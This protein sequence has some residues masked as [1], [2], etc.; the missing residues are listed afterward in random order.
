MQGRVLF[1]T[2]RVPYPLNDGGNLAMKAMIDGYHNAGW[3]VY[4]LSMN[5]SRHY[6]NEEE[7]SDLYNYLYAFET[8]NVDNKVTVQNVTSN[9]LFS[10][11]PSHAVRFRSQ[12]YAV[13]L[14]AV[15]KEFE[16]EVIQ[17]E[18][19][20]LSIYTSILKKSDAR[21]ILRL[22]NIESQIWYRLADE[23][24]NFVKKS[25]LRNLA[26]RI[27]TFEKK[28]FVNYDLLLPIT[29]VDAAVVNRINPS[30][31]TI[32]IPFGI[33]TKKIQP[34]IYQPEWKAYHIGAM[35]WLPNEEA[36]SWFL[37]NIWPDIY[38]VY[39]DLK[40]YYAG[41]N[42]PDYFSRKNIEGAV[43][44]GEVASAERFIEDKRML[45]VPLRSGGGIRVKIL[46]AMAAGKIV[47]STAVG[48]QGISATPGIHYLL[49]NTQD[50]FKKA[51]GWCMEN[52]ADAENVGL[53]ATLLIREKY[54]VSELMKLLFNQ[55]DDIK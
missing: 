40:F 2:N 36:I 47:I 45:I 26:G 16:P 15:I 8:V 4:L 11:E 54:D 39:P 23:T 6:V 5:T 7:V 18:S 55:I 3:E 20:Y 21:L 1:L 52:K 44:E 27:E 13:K 28:S 37:D 43:C 51:I 24:K 22:H 12:A 10:N 42:M 53:N 30:L 49:A 41:R 9:Y 14:E 38:N 31:K 33:D 32:T 25:Y 17:V 48:M 19:V 34:T 35:D 46:E 29:D 50:D